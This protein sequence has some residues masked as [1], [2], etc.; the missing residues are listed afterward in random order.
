MKARLLKCIPASRETKNG[1]R[2]P[3]RGKVECPDWDPK[4][5]CGNGLHA[6]R[7][8]P[9]DDMDCIKYHKEADCIWLVTDQIG[10]GVAMEA[11]ANGISYSNFKDE[12]AR[13]PDQRGKPYCSVWSVMRG[14]K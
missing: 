7:W 6:W 13:R 12:A 14:G 2:W 11:L 10:V 8:L 9:S 1:F 3:K 5:Q 4:P